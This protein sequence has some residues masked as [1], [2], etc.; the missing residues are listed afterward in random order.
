MKKIVEETALD[1][2][3]SIINI[4]E[5]LRVTSVVQRLGIENNATNPLIIALISW[6]LLSEDQDSFW[7]QRSKRVSNI[8]TNSKEKSIFRRNQS[9]MNDP[10]EELVFSDDEEDE[11]NVTQSNSL[12]E[13]KQSLRTVSELNPKDDLL[14][15]IGFSE[16]IKQKHLKV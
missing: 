6:M 1:S 4:S 10:D 3:K 13:V 16:K 9:L 14:F 12:Q 2:H 7:Q 5:F 11:G 8:S 15:L